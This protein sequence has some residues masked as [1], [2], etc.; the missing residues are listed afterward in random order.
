MPGPG[1]ALSKSHI[2][3]EAIYVYDPTAENANFGSL[4]CHSFNGNQ[5]IMKKENVIN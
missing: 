4:Q 2:Y 1:S 3:E 5:N